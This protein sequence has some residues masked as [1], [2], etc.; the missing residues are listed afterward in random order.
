MSDSRP[1]P[2][3]VRACPSPNEGTGKVPLPDRKPFARVTAIVGILGLALAYYASGR[4]GLSLAFL[5][6]SASAVWPPTGL[7]LASLVL[8]GQR[9]WPGIFIGAFFVN[10]ATTGSAF[11]SLGIA[12]GNTLEALLGAWFVVRFI[13]GAK[14]FDRTTDVFKFAFLAGTISTLVSATIG[15]TSLQLAGFVKPGQ[16]WPVWATWWVGDLVSDLVIA[17]LLL[18]WFSKPF[19]PL[20]RRLIIEAV[21][22]LLAIITVGQ[23]VFLLKVPFGGSNQP[24]EYLALPPLVWAALRLRQPGAITSAAMM[25]ALAIWG[26]RRGLGPFAGSDPNTSLLLLQTFMGTITLT[27]LAIAAVASERRRALQR[28]HVQDAVSRI[29]LEAATLQEA[30]PRILKAFCDVA[31]WEFG[32]LWH[33]D[34]QRHELYCVDTWH[35]PGLEITQFE[36]VTRTRRFTPGVGLPGAVWSSGNPEWIANVIHAPNFTRAAHAEKAGLRA[37]FC[38][39]FNLGAEVLGAIECFSREVRHPDED[40]LGILTS[41][42]SQLGQ[43]IERKRAEQQLRE[44]EQRFRATAQELQRAQAALS[45]HVQSLEQTIADRTANLRETISELEGFSYSISHDMRAPLRSMQSFSRLL[46]EEIGVDITPDQSDFLDRIVAASERLDCLVRDVL[47]YSKVA[48][49]DFPIENI[50]LQKLIEE[51]IAQNVNF[52]PP[53]ATIVISG[54]LPI[55]RGHAVA[56]GQCISN[57]LSNAVKFVA[58]GTAPS[59][60]IRAELRDGKVRIHFQDNGIG[61]DPKDQERIFRLFERLHTQKDYDGTGIGLAIVRKAAERIGGC[62]GLDSTPGK[63]S[64]FWLE[65]LRGVRQIQAD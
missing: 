56:L 3:S 7:A 59:V 1:L 33:L 58:P 50:N 6:A 34:R 43:F 23:I 60:Q 27:G 40:F 17:P 48:R 63:G 51:L 5:N 25:S 46:R 10:L 30:A 28:L 53:N 8:W 11:T 32:A 26:T 9:L 22:I 42:G 39:P 37:A 24:L 65:L 55:V 14:A 64:T 35:V 19:F 54:P 13:N 29:L 61:I 21:G 62:V 49:G 31:G 4:F 18:I 38:F 16:F 47:D 45:Q 20:S 36:H 2:G 12:A 52:Q 44:S 57:I 15:T 41:I